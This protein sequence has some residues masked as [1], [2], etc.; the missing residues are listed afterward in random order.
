MIGRFSSNWLL[1]AACAGA[2]AAMVWTVDAGAAIPDAAKSDPRF[3]LGYL[4]VTHYPAVTSI[5]ALNIAG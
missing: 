4:V 3:A 5:D 2:L 1:S